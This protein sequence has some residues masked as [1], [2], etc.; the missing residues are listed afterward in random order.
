[1]RRGGDGYSMFKD[2]SIN[3]YDGGSPLDV[4][5]GDYIRANAPI[6]PAVEGRITR[7]DG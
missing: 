5:L 2:N 1:M 3:P 6:A 7:V 4:V